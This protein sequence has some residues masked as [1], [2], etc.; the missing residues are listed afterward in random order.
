MDGSPILSPS[1][2]AVEQLVSRDDLLAVAQADGTLSLYEDLELRWSRTLPGGRVRRLAL[3]EGHVVAGSTDGVLRRIALDS[4]DEL[5]SV[6]IST[7]PVTEL[8]ERRGWIA[9]LAG[10]P[11]HL[12]LIT[13]EGRTIGPI[14]ISLQSYGL[15]FSPDGNL[16]AVGAGENA[17]AVAEE[18]W[19]LKLFDARSGEEV[20]T[21][22]IADRDIGRLQSIAWSPSGERL[23]TGSLGSSLRLW[24][25][26][27]GRVE[28]TFQPDRGTIMQLEFIDERRALVGS[29]DDILELWDLEAGI[30]I[31]VLPDYDA[32][33]YGWARSGARLAYASREIGV[34]I[35]RLADPE[36]QQTLLERTG[37]AT[38][39]RICRET[40]EAVPIVPFPP[41]DSVWAPE[42][43][44]EKL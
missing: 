32:N 39:L 31:Q 38:N 3:T 19:D 17:S 14:Q 36:D 6:E 23:L 24:N 34:M 22:S 11:G 25:I 5:S 26:A 9:A 40:A 16:L 21:S 29:L 12:V 7:F 20:F 15:S 37:A 10:A 43:S 41:A 28:A 27:E 8:K 4:P 18:G 35:A 1:S 2:S 44:C 30:P 33:L 13:P 42:A